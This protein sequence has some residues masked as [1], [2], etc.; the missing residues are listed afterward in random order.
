M[1]AVLF[2]FGGTAF[3]IN[4]KISWLSA[5]FMGFLSGLAVWLRPEAL[6]LDAFYV[7]SIILLRRKQNQRADLGFL[8]G[9]LIPICGFFLFNIIEFN[10]FLGIHGY[11]VLNETTF[12]KFIK[13][14]KNLLVINWLLLKFF[15][16]VL[17]MIPI[18]YLII[19]RK[20]PLDLSVRLLF[21]TAATF[22]AFAP[23]LLPNRG[24]G[25]WGPRYFLPVI[26]IVIVVFVMIS[27]EWKSTEI[28]KKSMGLITFF[29]VCMIYCTYLNTFKGGIQGLRWGNY[30]R[31]KPALV[32][33]RQQNENI[34]VVSTE[35]IPMEMGAI[36][37]DKKFF[38]AEN[39]ASLD[40]LIT[41]LKNQHLHDFLYINENDI[42]PG[43]PNLLNASRTSLLKKGN[44]YFGKYALE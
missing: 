12:T 13:G 3:I 6:L 25:Q 32:F 2:L 44:Y 16:F 21:L 9:M 24:G 37:R 42:S 40:S 36:F 27:E 20:W 30:N 35:H 41:L 23:F 7:A 8:W 22:C 34:I 31:V 26:P 15:P 11:Q 4:R 10:S 29:A 5:A 18:S 17:L 33:T 14:I 38:L 19:G 1:P 28:N 43:F 39:Q